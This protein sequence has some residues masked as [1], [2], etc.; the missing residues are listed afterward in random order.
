MKATLLRILSFLMLMATGLSAQTT[1]TY[2]NF[3]RQIQMPSGVEWELS[4]ISANGERQSGLSV[5]DDGARFEL[6]T[7]KSAPLTSYLLDSKFVGAYIPTS[8]VTIR[9]EDPYTIIPRTRADRPFWVDVN[10]TGLSSNL[11]APL[12]ARSVTLLHHTQ[13]Y[14]TGIGD[15]LNRLLATLASQTS[16][17]GNG[18]RRFSYQVTSIAGADR[19]KVRGEERFSIFSL[20]D[21]LSPASQLASQYIQIWPVGTG[22]IA[23]ITEGEMFRSKIRTITVGATD[24]YPDSRTYLQIYKGP[25]L[26]GTDG[27]VV[28]SSVMLGDGN[29]PKDDARPV[30]LDNYVKSDGVWTVELLTSTPFGIDRLAKVSFQ[31]GRSLHVNSLLGTME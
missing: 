8:G 23:G 29:K 28:P 13:S 24:M 4:N 11:L 19:T 6:W 26:L 10:V 21:L 9:S 22:S 31:V 16:I 2:T 12:A 27:L 25:A 30:D 1:Y 7:I 18:E 5:A 14:G 20:A 3:I 15:N 17:G